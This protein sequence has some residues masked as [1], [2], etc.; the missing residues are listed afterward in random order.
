MSFYNYHTIDTINKLLHELCYNSIIKNEKI[1]V[2][3][4]L[5]L[6]DIVEEQPP[7]DSVENKLFRI[8]KAAGFYEDIEVVT[9]KIKKLFSMNGLTPMLYMIDNYYINFGGQNISVGLEW[10]SAPNGI[11]TTDMRDILVI[12][13]V[14]N[15]FTQEY[16]T[17]LLDSDHNLIKGDPARS[18]GKDIDTNIPNWFIETHKKRTN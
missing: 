18:F 17:A 7:I 13:V 11:T 2:F 5:E 15:R 12:N 4:P 6:N 1:D 3:K 14:G 10:G 16:K 8:A 9:S